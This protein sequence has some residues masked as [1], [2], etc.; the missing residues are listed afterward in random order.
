M[1]PLVG[2][3]NP[4]EA[5]APAKNRAF[6]ERPKAEPKAARTLWSSWSSCGA[7]KFVWNLQNASSLVLTT[8]DL[9]LS[10]CSFGIISGAADKGQHCHLL[11]S[12]MLALYV[13]TFYIIL[14]CNKGSWDETL[15]MYRVMKRKHSKNI[16][17]RKSNTEKRQRK[18][19]N[20]EKSKE[21]HIRN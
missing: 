2:L 9:L 17:K 21:K 20:H 13:Y 15:P 7:T 19:I 4:S 1:N 3:P 16:K 8:I 6:P 11:R 14:Q 5:E 10:N 12:A 18:T